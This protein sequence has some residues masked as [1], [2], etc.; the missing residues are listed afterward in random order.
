[1]WQH[2]LQ[3]QKPWITPQVSR[4][5][6]LAYST[7]TNLRNMGGLSVTTAF[8]AAHA[9]APSHPRP[10]FE[11]LKAAGV[12]EAWAETVLPASSASTLL[13]L[14]NW[15]FYLPR[16][17]PA[18]PGALDMWMRL[19]S[20][21]RITQAA[22]PYIMDSF[23]FNMN[24][25]IIAPEIRQML[26]E[27]GLL[28]EQRK[29]PSRQAKTKSPDGAEQ[30]DEEELETTG[31]RASLWI[32]TVVMNL[33]VKAALPEEGADWLAVRI[34]AKQIKDGRFDME[35]IVRDVDDELIALS[36]HVALMLDVERAAKSKSKAT[37]KAVL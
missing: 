17:E 37:S 11:A 20:G 26:R 1:M 25:Y 9:D 8:E 36:H 4:R 3:S 31:G 12:D 16:A 14:R 23:P 29:Q 35:V 34:V 19:A 30:E 22:F 24:E 13:S 10:D 18:V 15:H 33:E 27:Q 5:I 2:G 6:I 7:H 28:M 21:E 32:P